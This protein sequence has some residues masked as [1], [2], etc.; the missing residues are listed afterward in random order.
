[1]RKTRHHYKNLIFDEE[2]L[3]TDLSAK[4]FDIDF[5][6][7]HYITFTLRKSM[8]SNG[9]ICGHFMASVVSVRHITIDRISIIR[10]TAV[11][12][13]FSLYNVRKL[14]RIFQTMWKQHILMQY[15]YK[16]VYL[17][18]ITSALK[19]FRT[20][21]QIKFTTNLNKCNFE[22]YPS[23]FYMKKLSNGIRGY[24]L[25]WSKIR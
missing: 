7:T 6:F 13:T 9:R 4:K 14:K 2:D 19:V 8:L 18:C 5:F 25:D 1:M 10:N 22:I 12:Y 16:S 11:F 23:N 15:E 21:I 24:I 20:L 3:K 17:N